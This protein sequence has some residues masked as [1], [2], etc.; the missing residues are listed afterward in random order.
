[1]ITAA[2]GGRREREGERRCPVYYRG[3]LRQTR[4]KSA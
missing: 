3:V 1:M 2:A 4:P